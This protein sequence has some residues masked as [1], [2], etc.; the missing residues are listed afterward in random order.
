MWSDI[1]GYILYKC[2]TFLPYK[3][4]VNAFVVCQSWRAKLHS[5]RI[6]W[7]LWGVKCENKFM[8]YIIEKQLDIELEDDECLITTVQ[9]MRQKVLKSYFVTMLKNYHQHCVIDYPSDVLVNEQEPP[10]MKSWKE[11]YIFLLQSDIER[12]ISVLMTNEILYRLIMSKKDKQFEHF[13]DISCQIKDTVDEEQIQNDARDNW[14]V[15]DGMKQKPKPLPTQKMVV[16]IQQCKTFLH[17]L[18]LYVMFVEPPHS[19][20]FYMNGEK[21]HQSIVTFNVISRHKKG[22]PPKMYNIEARNMRVNEVSALSVHC[23]DM[24]ILFDPVVDDVIVQYDVGVSRTILGKRDREKLGKLMG[25]GDYYL[26][27]NPNPLTRLDVG[28]KKAKN[29]SKWGQEDQERYAREEQSAF[30]M[31]PVKVVR[32]SKLCMDIHVQDLYNLVMG[33]VTIDK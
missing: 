29:M 12:C 23:M 21:G 27:N 10:Q 14:L 6:D 25:V 4:I 8:K 33:I 1:D 18:D 20:T 30:D 26:Q 9:N 13:L 19:T 3:D 11:I 5:Q 2:A 31:I 17:S 28:H 15:F 24:N 22:S 16:D 32:T 7:L